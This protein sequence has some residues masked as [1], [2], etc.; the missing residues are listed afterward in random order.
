M[1]STAA[2]IRLTTTPFHPTL[3]TIESLPTNTE[4]ADVA[5]TSA[6]SASFLGS[7]PVP[8]VIPQP[9]TTPTFRSMHDALPH[10]VRWAVDKLEMRDEGLHVAAALMRGKCRAISDGSFKYERATSAFTLQGY[11]STLKI[12][13]CNLVPGAKGEASAYRGELGGIYGI[14][15]VVQLLCAL[16]QIEQ[17]SIV[18]GLDG[19]STFAKIEQ[20]DTPHPH[21]GHY[22]LL[23]A[24]RRIIASLPIE[25]T[26]RY[27]AGHQ[28]DVSSNLD[29]WERQNVRMDARAKRHLHNTLHLPVPNIRIGLE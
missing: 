26:L 4:L 12:D 27:V 3:Q 7:A 2:S 28:D 10:T 6:T 14:L 15:V 8:D 25:V 1:W 11:K 29:W 13:T 16:H 18:I 21:V 22:D 19:K 20:Q 5:V 9:I 23:L 17:G 24:I